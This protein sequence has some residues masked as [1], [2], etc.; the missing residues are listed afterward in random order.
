MSDLYAWEEAT[1]NAPKKKEASAVT[2]ERPPPR[3]EVELKK[4]DAKQLRRDANTIKDYYDA[5][6]K[7]D[8]DAELEEVVLYQPTQTKQ[9]A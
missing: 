9:N 1:N 2:L 8:V 7:F 3:G 5:W 4:T 6:N